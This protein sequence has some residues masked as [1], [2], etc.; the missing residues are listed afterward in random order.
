[1]SEKV[2]EEYARQ[3]KSK[4]SDA[5]SVA[6]SPHGNFGIVN[7][8]YAIQELSDREVTYAFS[9]D[10]TNV[11]RESAQ[12]ET[13]YDDV[14]MIEMFNYGWPAEGHEQGAPF[15]FNWERVGD[16]VLTRTLYSG[17]FFLQNACE[18]FNSMTPSYVEA[19]IVDNFDE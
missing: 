16:R 7:L 9:F 15:W 12:D 17:E 13:D 10:T 4:L 18:E 8:D 2:A 19:S 3:F 14:N 5:T 1:M 11:M 6:L